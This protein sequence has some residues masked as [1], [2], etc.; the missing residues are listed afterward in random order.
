[1]KK[2]LL[3]PLLF[4]MVGCSHFR[5]TAYNC[6]NIRLNEPNM[7]NI[8]EECRDY[9][10]EDATKSTYPPGEQSIELNKDFNIGK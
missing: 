1:M 7:N 4:L 9:S 5:V 8:P 2:Y 3:L 10:E 6:D